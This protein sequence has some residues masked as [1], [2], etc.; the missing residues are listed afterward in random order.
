MHIY[1]EMVKTQQN[2]WLKEAMTLIRPGLEH[3]YHHHHEQ[4]RNISY[5]SLP[6][7]SK[8]TQISPLHPF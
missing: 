4:H 8:L 2:Q 6:V 3:H 7:K 1:T 5:H